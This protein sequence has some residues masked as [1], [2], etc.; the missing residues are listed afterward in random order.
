MLNWFR[1]HKLRRAIEATTH[2]IRYRDPLTQ[3]ALN[4]ALI[5]HLNALLVEERRMLCTTPRT[6]DNDEPIDE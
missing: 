3:A 6:V 1:H 4:D 5:E 2:A